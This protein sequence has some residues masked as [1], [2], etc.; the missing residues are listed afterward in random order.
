M[1]REEL[2]RQLRLLEETAV[3]AGHKGKLAA[4]AMRTVREV[5]AF[6][7]EQDALKESRER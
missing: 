7:R 1:T 4:V 5:E 6:L 2:Q 3:S